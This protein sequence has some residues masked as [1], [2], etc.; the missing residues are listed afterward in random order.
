MA[1][2]ILAGELHAD[3]GAFGEAI[4]ALEE[5]LP[6]EANLA[7][8]E[9]VPWFIPV[10]HVPGAVLPEADRPQDAEQVYREQLQTHSENGWSLFE[11]AQALTAQGREMEAQDMEACFAEAMQRSDVWLTGSRY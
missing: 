9:P 6:P 1:E 10:R 8:D 3:E 4:A 7:Y 11:L 2:G 5:A